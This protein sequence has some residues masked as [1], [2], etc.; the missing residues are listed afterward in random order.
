MNLLEMM[1]HDA[2]INEMAIQTFTDDGKAQA[3]IQKVMNLMNSGKVANKD[4]TGIIE[5]A[6]KF[7]TR[8]TGAQVKNKAYIKNADKVLAM[9]KAQKDKLS[10]N[11]AR[12]DSK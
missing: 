8:D 7:L 5:S 9:I 2:G 4:Y 1:R 10:S 11:Q 3:T 6:K 12:I